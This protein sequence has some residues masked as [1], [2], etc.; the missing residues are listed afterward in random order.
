MNY[1]QF[2]LIIAEIDKE[3][4]EKLREKGI[5]PDKINS[6]EGNNIIDISKNERED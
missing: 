2:K 4:K 6:T 1:K 5:D 3:K